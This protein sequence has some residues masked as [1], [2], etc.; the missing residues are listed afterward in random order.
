MND[1]NVGFVTCPIYFCSPIIIFLPLG[2]LQK[3]INANVDL[4][5]LQPPNNKSEMGR[6]KKK[7]RPCGNPECNRI[8][9]TRTLCAR[10]QKR[11]QRGKLTSSDGSLSQD[12][13][14]KKESPNSPDGLHSPKSSSHLSPNN[15]NG[16]R[17]R[18]LLPKGFNPMIGP[19]LY[20]LNDPKAY[21]PSIPFTVAPAQI[22]AVQQVGSNVWK[23][24]KE[25]PPNDPFKFLLIERCFTCI[26][27]QELIIHFPDY[28][29]SKL[30]QVKN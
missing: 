14:S 8:I 12:G 20:N 1:I 10:C 6:N 19:Y 22:I 18:Q 13:S 3:R 26:P 24:V 9:E 29:A 4:N 7:P 23:I 25:L 15:M 21:L 30:Q 28:F 27:T 16:P 2:D 11:K 5:R 17:F